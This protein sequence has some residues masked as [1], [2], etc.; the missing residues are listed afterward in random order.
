MLFLSQP[1]GV[2][3]S[4]ETTDTGY[5]NPYTGNVSSNP[6]DG[7]TIGTYSRVDPDRFDTTYISAVGA[8]VS[9]FENDS[10]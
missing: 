4:Y 6:I 8:W 1:V 2:G 7:E 5:L 10:G 3:F 9:S